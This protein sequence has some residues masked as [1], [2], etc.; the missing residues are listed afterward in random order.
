MV[1]PTLDSILFSSRHGGIVYTCISL[2]IFSLI[3]AYVYFF[4]VI[5]S[6]VVLDYFG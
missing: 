1:L 5:V 2:S 6:I 3:F 4:I